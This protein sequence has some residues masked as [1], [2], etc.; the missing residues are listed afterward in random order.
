M[1]IIMAE[2]FKRMQL[3]CQNFKVLIFVI[4][5]FAFGCSSRQSDQDYV[6]SFLSRAKKYENDLNIL[7]NVSYKVRGFEGGKPYIPR[8]EIALNETETITLPGLTNEM[9]EEAISKAPFIE[10]MNLYAIKKGIPDSLA[11]Q[12]VKQ[13]LTKITSLA[14]KLEV[15]R[16]QSTP[17]LGNFIIFY[18]TD[19]DQVI[20][21]QDLESVRYDN[22]QSF[23]ESGQKLSQKWYYRKL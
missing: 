1:G 18:V 16:V 19:Q 11:Y 5:V 21:L 7:Q 6:N 23:F 2:N 15:Y 22:W 12:E 10:N 3:F 17:R 13:Y 9:D 8:L 20:Y 14:E 4:V